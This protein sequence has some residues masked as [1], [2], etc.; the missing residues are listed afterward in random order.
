MFRFWQMSWEDCIL[1][2]GPLS[3]WF[4]NT[5][6]A[7]LS[8][9]LCF[10]FLLFF[11]VPQSDPPAWVKL[12]HRPLITSEFLSYP[13]NKE[14]AKVI[15]I[16]LPFPQILSTLT[17]CFHVPLFASTFGR[18]L[19]PKHKQKKLILLIQSFCSKLNFCSKLGKCQSW[20]LYMPLRLL[21]FQF[22]YSI[23]M[24]L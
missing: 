16:N 23:P 2:W 10:V 17:S 15:K 8:N 22:C 9:A 24:R 11:S 12:Y 3:P 21:K 7:P 20:K 18:S 5:S 4:C 19:F 6:S 1:F 13:K 14:I